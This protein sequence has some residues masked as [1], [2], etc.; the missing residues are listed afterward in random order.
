MTKSTD[1]IRWPINLDL[2]SRPVSGKMKIVRVMYRKEKGENC[3]FESLEFF[4]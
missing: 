2:L 1:N 3:A 4:N